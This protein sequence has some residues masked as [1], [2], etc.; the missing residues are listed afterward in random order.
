MCWEVG[1]MDERK[2]IDSETG[3]NYTWGEEVWLEGENQ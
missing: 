3:R 2:E 1:R